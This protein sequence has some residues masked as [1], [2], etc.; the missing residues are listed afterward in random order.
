MRS[1]ESFAIYIFVWEDRSKNQ[2]HKIHQEDPKISM[3]DWQKKERMNERKEETFTKNK[4]RIFHSD[5]LGPISYS[6]LS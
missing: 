3:G 4:I 1:V 5:S 2:L 6:I